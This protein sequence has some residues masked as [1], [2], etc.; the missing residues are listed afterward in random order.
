MEENVNRKNMKYFIIKN[1]EMPWGDYGDVLFTGL[2]N[3]MDSNFN[4]MVFPELERTGPYIPEIYIANSRNVI[5][6][7]DVKQM[8]EQNN[9][10]G[11]TEFRHVIKKKIVNI[12][13]KSWDKS[14]EPLFIPE[15]NEP[16]DYILKGE[17]DIDLLKSTTDV[18]E[19]KMVKQY[20]LTKISDK[21]DRVYYTHLIMDFKPQFDIFTPQNILVVIISEKLKNIFEAHNI[22]T[23]RYIE[24]LQ[25]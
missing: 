17:N 3:V 9:I 16:E 25:L 23:L 13:W 11:I 22:N 12:N 5:V 10:S 6:T 18:W 19:L 7:D 14:Q 15:S 8:I 20:N 2:L 21:I 1:Q 24:I 4:D